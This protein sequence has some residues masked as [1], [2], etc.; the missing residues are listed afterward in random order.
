[1]IPGIPKRLQSLLNDETRAYAFL[2]TTMPDGSPQV[3]PVW[4]DVTDG[5]IRINT[6]E[7]RVKWHNMRRLRKV[8][9]AIVDP[10]DPY[11]YVQIRGEV[12]GW[13]T[14]GA[15]DHIDRL[16]GK[17]RGVARYDGPVDQRR[18]IFTIR[19]QAVAPKE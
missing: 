4:F 8:A 16:A 15:R 10:D 13:T 18:V 7:G 9:I 17:Y 3:T 5:K 6:A 11:R 1:M 14:E 2:A 19:P 12:E